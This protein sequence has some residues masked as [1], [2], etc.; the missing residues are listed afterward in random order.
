MEK[1]LRE[2]FIGHELSH[3]QSVITL[4]AAPDQIRQTLVPEQ[5]HSSSFLLQPN[6]PHIFTHRIIKQKTK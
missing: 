2:S 5:P 6:P 1:M 3:K 4:A